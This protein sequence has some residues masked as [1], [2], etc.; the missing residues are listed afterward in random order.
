[1]EEVKGRTAAKNVLFHWIK[2]F[3]NLLKHIVCCTY[4]KVFRRI[5]GRV[6][7]SACMQ[8]TCASILKHRM[9]RGPFQ[10]DATE[11]RTMFIISNELDM[12]IQS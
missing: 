10:I 12:K 7:N 6:P 8:L 9:R 2:S 1:M 11:E 3:I 5:K 4:H